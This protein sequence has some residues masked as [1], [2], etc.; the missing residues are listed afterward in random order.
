MLPESLTQAEMAN[1]QLL[2]G[3][4]NQLLEQVGRLQ[5]EVTNLRSSSPGRNSDVADLQQE[6]QGLKDRQE[7]QDRGASAHPGGLCADS[8]CAPCVDTRGRYAQ[9]MAKAVEANRH[10]I[11]ATL[12]QAAQL[13]DLVDIA[14]LLGQRFVEIEKGTPGPQAIQIGNGQRLLLA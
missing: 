14:T 7:I 6:V 13:E 4:L 2:M 11:F 1:G 12:N 10:K 9:A 5:I 8:A 3:R